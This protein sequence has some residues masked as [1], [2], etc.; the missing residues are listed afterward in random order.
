LT[1]DS[2][3]SRLRTIAGFSSRRSTLRRSNRATFAGSKP[4]ND[5]L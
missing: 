1:V 3:F 4:A 5:D 2:T